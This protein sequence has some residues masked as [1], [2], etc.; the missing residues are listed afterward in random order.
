MAQCDH[1]KTQPV[2]A[3][4]VCE[5]GFSGKCVSCSGVS[6]PSHSTV[7]PSQMCFILK[8]G[9]ALF[10]QCMNNS[11]LLLIK[12]R[13]YKRPCLWLSI[14]S[15]SSGKNFALEQKRPNTYSDLD[16]SLVLLVGFI[17]SVLYC[18]FY[19]Q[20]T[21][22]R[23]IVPSGKRVQEWVEA[24]G[25]AVHLCFPYSAGLE[26]C[27]WRFGPWKCSLKIYPS[28]DFCINSMFLQCRNIDLK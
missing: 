21:W 22:R 23:K 17:Q 6:F 26:V 20:A 14:T 15:Q 24:T 3:F 8:W 7:L 18:L 9:G 25:F 4:L 1:R 12:F 28:L 10:L 13:V 11:V 19:G 5:T 16:I 2:C 27:F